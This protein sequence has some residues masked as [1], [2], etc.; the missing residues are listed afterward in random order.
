MILVWGSKSY[1]KLVALVMLVCA[2]C[3]AP[4]AQ[5]LEEL[6][7]KFTLFWIPLFVYRRTFAITC[8]FCGTTSQVPRESVPALAAQDVRADGP[9]APASGA[10]GGRQVP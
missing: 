5:R 3:G 9:G 8:A 7:S 2:A 6:T 1:V 10:P 4:A